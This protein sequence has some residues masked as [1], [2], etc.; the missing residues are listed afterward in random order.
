[1][2]AQLQSE[3]AAL[4]EQSAKQQQHISQMAAESKKIAVQSF[5]GGSVCMSCS[6]TAQASRRLSAEDA[7]GSAYQ[8]PPK[9]QCGVDRGAI[10]REGRR[11]GNSGPKG[12]ERGGERRRG[13]M[14]TDPV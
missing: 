4:V 9:K 7:V 6:M 2:V 3:N 8:P 14:G 13:G 5:G 12:R 11:C 10:W 1:M